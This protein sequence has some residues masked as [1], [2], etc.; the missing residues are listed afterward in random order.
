M[1]FL[2]V[3]LLLSRIIF[4]LLV[5]LLVLLSWCEWRFCCITD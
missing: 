1:Q 5:L 2:D 4:T 3:V